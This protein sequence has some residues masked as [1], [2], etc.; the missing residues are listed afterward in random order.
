M[1]RL[2]LLQADWMDT[3]AR[4]PDSDGL[5]VCP[6]EKL[7]ASERAIC[8]LMRDRIRLRE[9][10]LYMTLLKMRLQL[11]QMQNIYKQICRTPIFQQ[12]WKYNFYVYFTYILQV[13]PW[14]KY[15][16][17]PYLLGQRAVDLR[18]AETSADH[19][20]RPQEPRPRPVE[21]R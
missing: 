2:A 6:R 1:T 16:S 18:A 15:Y 4:G 8:G 10:C 5:R 14:G 11:P 7:K 21:K 17:K 13:Q 20:P 19:R 9:G 12:E 3:E